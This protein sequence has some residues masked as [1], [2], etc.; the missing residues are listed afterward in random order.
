[1]LV[2]ED[3]ERAGLQFDNEEASTR[4]ATR[5]D[6][7]VLDRTYK[8]GKKADCQALAD[9]DMDVPQGATVQ[10]QT[11]DGD[12]RIVGV[13]AAYAGSQNGDI[14]I[15][16]AAKLVEAGSVGGSISLRDSTGRINLSSAGGGV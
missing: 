12:I 9:V 4:P 14:V 10:V 8:V 2:S 3:T 15:E 5:I 7:M 1:M 16:R 11:R 13:S 6:V